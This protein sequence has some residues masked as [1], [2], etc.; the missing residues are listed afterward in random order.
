MDL[1]KVD[2]FHEL[3]MKH[4]EDVL[5]ALCQLSFAPLKKPTSNNTENADLINLELLED[6]LEITEMSYTVW[7]KL[8]QNKNKYKECLI[9]LQKEI[10]KPYIIR[11][12]LILFGSKVLSK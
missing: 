11:K 4:L 3:V 8:E 5:A 1:N 9:T 12:L 10:Y 7:N 6:S 2:V